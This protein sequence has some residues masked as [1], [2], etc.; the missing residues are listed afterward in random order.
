MD[1][2]NQELPTY[3]Q[4][5]EYMQ[6]IGLKPLEEY[7]FK[8]FTTRGFNLITKKWIDEQDIT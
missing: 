5:I 3:E 4:Y 7:A 6:S 2:R 1:E 8:V